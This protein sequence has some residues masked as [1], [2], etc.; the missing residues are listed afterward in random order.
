MGGRQV[1]RK[2]AALNRLAR[3]NL[4]RRG[5]V[6]LTGNLHLLL[7]LLLRNRR[8]AH[9]VSKPLLFSALLQ[10]NSPVSAHTRRVPAPSASPIHRGRRKCDLWFRRL[11]RAQCLVDPLRDV[12]LRPVLVTARLVGAAY[13]RALNLCNASQLVLH[14]AVRQHHCASL[15]LPLAYSTKIPVAKGLLLTA[16]LR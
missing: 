12:L 5:L 11:L 6:P 2:G 9:L 3:S 8:L 16:I 10:V 4:L 1:A 13:R 14:E 7:L 15:S